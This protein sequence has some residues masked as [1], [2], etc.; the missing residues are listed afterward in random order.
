VGTSEL[1]SSRLGKLSRVL[2]VGVGAIV[3]CGA[4]AVAATDTTTPST[5][6]SSG[7]S[8]PSGEPVEIAQFVAIQANPVE[9]VIIQAA[10]EVA[11]AD[12]NVNLTVFDANNDPQAQ[13]AQCQDALAQGGFDAFILKAVA[14]PTMIDCA[15][16]AIAQGIPVVAMGN[17]LGPDSAS[18]EL[19]VE[20][21]SASVIH[22]ANTNG[23]GLYELIDLACDETDD[24]V[25]EVVY[26]FGP[27]AFD[28]A[29]ISRETL[30]A[31]LDERDDVEVVAEQTQ[32]FNPDEAINAA[33][34]LLPAN[35]GTDVLAM[36]CSFCAVPIVDVVAE[37]GLSEDVLIVASGTDAASIPQIAAGQQF[38]QVMLLPATESRLATEFAIKA[39]RGEDL[40]D[41]V[42]VDV[43]ADYSPTGS[44]I[45]TQEDADEF[46]AEWPLGS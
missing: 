11:E 39:A 1:Y 43:A 30:Y 32:N 12:G 45:L 14:G 17:A 22:S 36:D 19:Q 23:E 40:G 31:L 8:A 26:L 37:L 20:G 5:D 21:L 42:T 29:S 35:P 6:A 9:E 3:A 10:A 4:G 15:E 24:P 18:V 33:R 13:I 46:T 2:V 41:D 7:S 38:G 16:Q 25:C 27:L 34:Q 28:Y 44:I